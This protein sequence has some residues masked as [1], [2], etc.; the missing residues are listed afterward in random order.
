MKILLV[1]D[2]TAILE[3][4]EILFR[5]EGYEVA[6]ADSG[7]K[8]IAAACRGRADSTSCPRRA[9]SIPRCPSSS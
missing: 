1:D 2:E 7:P 8:A 4:L 6:V 3:A 5:G 9:R